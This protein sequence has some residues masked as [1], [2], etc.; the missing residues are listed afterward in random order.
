M[1][2]M[3]YGRIRRSYIG[4]GG[5]TIPLP[6]R[7][8]RHYQLLKETAVRVMSLE[9][10][11]PAARAGLREGD[12]IIEFGSYSIGGVDDLHRLL[13][14]ERIGRKVEVVVI[15][16]SEKIVIDLTPIEKAG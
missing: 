4:I 8:A 15:R 16:R 5:Q 14:P 2:L 10:G 11:G 7:I 1:Q 13:M 12:T 9:E 6:R 3:K